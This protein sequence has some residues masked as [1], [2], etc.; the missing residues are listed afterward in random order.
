VKDSVVLINFI[1]K[2]LIKHFFLIYIISFANT[3]QSEIIVLQ[4]YSQPKL[5]YQLEIFK[6]MQTAIPTEKLK[7]VFNIV[8]SWRTY[9][10][11]GSSEF[12][13]TTYQEKINT[14][15]RLLYFKTDFH[16]LIA[17]YKELHDSNKPL[18]NNIG[19]TFIGLISFVRTGESFNYKTMLKFEE[20]TDETI[21]NAFVES[22]QT[23]VL[24]SFDF[25]KYINGFADYKAGGLGLDYF[26]QYE[27]FKINFNQAPD[28]LKEWDE[29]E[30]NEFA[31]SYQHL[32]NFLNRQ[33]FQNYH[34]NNMDQLYPQ[35]GMAKNVEGL[36]RKHLPQ[37][38]FEQLYKN[39]T[40]RKTVLF[41]MLKEV[42][43]SV[44][45][46]KD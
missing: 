29:E 41:N 36:I 37:E 11:S 14:L 24:P 31:N 21:I 27:F 12:Y 20:A 16:K 8:H 10:D 3:L 42:I 15:S 6:Y 33:L 19:K 30:E 9:F 39:E 44:Y 34:E 35:M 23:L 25:N 26:S 22:I 1:S 32:F 28:F 17:E 43:E 46:C 13:T 38:L 45:F 4:H 18:L 7:E 40:K 5:N 2:N